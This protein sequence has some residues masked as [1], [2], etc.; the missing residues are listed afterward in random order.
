MNK[1]PIKIKIKTG[2]TASQKEIKE[3]INLSGALAQPKASQV[4]E[5]RWLMPLLFSLL[6]ISLAILTA[7]FFIARTKN[8]SPLKE[9]FPEQAKVSILFKTQQA[10]NIGY[11]ISSRLE[12]DYPFYQWLKARAGQ[13]LDEA[14]V[15][16]AKDIAPLLKDEAALAILD[17][18]EKQKLSWLLLTQIKPDKLAQKEIIFS[19]IEQVLKKNFGFNQL[20]YRQI[21]ISRA[22]SLSQADESYF[23]AQIN[24]F[25]VIGN[26]LEEI[27]KTIDRIIEN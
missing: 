4:K 3:A 10:G 9:Y 11:L 2:Q 20:S 25:F 1:F 7:N 27:E 26:S 6:F 12:K 23:Y 21:R 5:K 24:T 13:I 14:G 16:A 22:Y 8:S 15:S 17:S 19:K 18:D